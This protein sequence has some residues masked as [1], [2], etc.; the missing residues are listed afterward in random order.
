MIKSVISYVSKFEHN[1]SL[2]L[3]CGIFITDCFNPV[4]VCTK[5]QNMQ[6]RNN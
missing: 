3:Q 6:I 4:V 1:N 5:W 2:I